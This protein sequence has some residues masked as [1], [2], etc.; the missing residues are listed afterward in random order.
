MRDH[1]QREEFN[2]EA[3]FMGGKIRQLTS[4]H[5]SELDPDR[6]E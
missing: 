1:Y 4:D 5:A 2:E 6:V 3:P